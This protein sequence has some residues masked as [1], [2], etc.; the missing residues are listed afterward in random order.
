MIAATWPRPNRARARLLLL[1][2]ASGALEHRSADALPEVLRPGDLL[3]LND[4]ATLPASL[5]GS[6]NGAPLE[7]RLM[8]ENAGLWRAVAFG[9][10]SWRT[11]TERRLPPPALAPGAR[12]TFGNLSATVEAVLPPSPPTALVVEA[13]TVKLPLP[14]KFAAGVNFNPA[15]P[16]A[17][18]MKS[19]L[20]IS[21]VPLFWYSV[22]L[23]M[24]VIWKWVTSA[25]SAALRLITR[26]VVL[27]VS[28]LVVALVTE[29][30][31]TTGLTVIVTVAT[32]EFATPSLAL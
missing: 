22:P 30:V 6:A 28:S 19:P 8:D 16:C 2:R 31:S 10:G 12:L 26:P 17:T 3:V 24:P 23:L 1:D 21:V 11:P 7:L 4:A 20:L 14:L 15:L 27:C 9:A 29:G 32:F 13:C 25:P 18:V 5:S